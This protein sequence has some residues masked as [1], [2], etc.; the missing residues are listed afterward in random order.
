MDQVL[1]QRKIASISKCL[2]IPDVI[3][4]SSAL[5]AGYCDG[6]LFVQSK[7]EC[8]V[9]NVKDANIRTIQNQAKFVLFCLNGFALITEFGVFKYYKNI[10]GDDR[11]T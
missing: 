5:F 10:M 3:D 7:G 6:Q 4:I 8:Q 2:Q 11:H 1:V 9:W